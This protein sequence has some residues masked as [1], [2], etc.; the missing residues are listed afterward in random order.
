MTAPAANLRGKTFS[1]KTEFSFWVAVFLSAAILVLSWFTLR[2]EREAL[3]Q[4]VTRRGV[5]LA[6]YVATHSLDPFLTD[7]K[8]SLATLVGDVMKNQDMVYALITDRNGRV[9]ASDRSELVGRAYARPPGDH[10]LDR[11]EARAFTWTHPQAGPVIDI[12]IPLILEGRTKIGEVHLG[13]SRR[14]IDTVVA[15]AWRQIMGLA[16]IFLIVGVLGSLL[17]VSFMLRPVA[18]LTRGA[19]AIGSGDLD[20]QIPPMRL[21]EL[22]RLAETFNHMTRELKVATAQAIEQEKIKKELQVAHQIQ[23]ALLPKA[24][25]E[26]KG[27]TFASLYRAAKEVGGD[28]YDF[29]WLDRERVAVVLADVCG[30]GVPAALLM[31][32]ARSMLRCLA[33]SLGSPAVV[34]RELNRLLHDDLRG[35]LFITLFYAVLD[36]SKRTVTYTSAGH[37]PGL[38][39]RP[40]AAAFQ[41]LGLEPPCLPLGLDKS[42]VFERLLKERKVTLAPH[43]VVVLY[44]DGVTEAMNGAREEFGEDGL[45]SCLRRT[46]RTPI[47]APAVIRGLDEALNT[48]CGDVPQND[49]IAAVA[50]TVD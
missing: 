40:K 44:T 47:G 1:V 18:A 36:V 35:G 9:L 3:T 32:V 41:T 25:P 22:G 27:L 5:A 49:D 48:F 34:A 10:S 23:M 33:P 28:Y 50:I 6:Q 42:G 30:K 39:W 7:D 31:S 21:N 2:Q 45:M 29:I 17:M 16:A 8:L 4:E 19:Q 13:V 43:D 15:V 14:T 38:L 11:P 12:G 46:S 24:T 37:N 26:V 20:H